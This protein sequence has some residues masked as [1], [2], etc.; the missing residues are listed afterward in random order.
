MFKYISV[1][2]LTILFAFNVN[3][4]SAD[5]VVVDLQKVI[6]NSKAAAKAESE[7]QTRLDK[8]QSEMLAKQEEF[9][10]KS[11][12]L[13]SKSSVLSPEVF[14]KEREVLARELKMEEEKL[15]SESKELEEVFNLAQ[16]QIR[17]SVDAII[18][19]L[20]QKNNYHAVLP[21]SQTLYFNPNKDISKDVVELLNQRLPQLDL[22][23]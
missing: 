7:I 8:F 5:I 10:K 6:E 11:E 23:L 3:A 9:K 22:P 18:L 12:D 20:S 15:F 21:K 17:I 19:E 2:L 1:F 13:Q 16:K 4:T 14:N